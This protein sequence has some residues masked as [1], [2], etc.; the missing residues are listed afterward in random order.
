[1]WRVR[2]LALVRGQVQALSLTWTLRH[3]IDEGSPLF[4]LSAADLIEMDAQFILSVTGT[5]ATLAAPVHAVRAYDPPDVLWGYRF[6][7]VMTEDARGLTRV[8]LA[9]L[10]DVSAA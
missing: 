7:D 5:D 1:M 4:G 9:R 2:D 8:A 6:D 3:V 10:H